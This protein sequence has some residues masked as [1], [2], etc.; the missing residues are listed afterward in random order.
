MNADSHLKQF[1]WGS[2]ERRVVC[3]HS[4]R[5]APQKLTTNP[6]CMPQLVAR[7]VRCK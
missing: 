5:T 4:L 2:G 1:S 7:Q 6:V 3:H